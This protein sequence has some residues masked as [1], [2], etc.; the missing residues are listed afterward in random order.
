MSGAIWVRQVVSLRSGE[1]WLVDVPSRTGM[2]FAFENIASCATLL[3]MAQTEMREAGWPKWV[4]LKATP[5]RAWA[6]YT[7]DMAGLLARA[8]APSG[9]VGAL[10]PLGGPGGPIVVYMHP[11]RAGALDLGGM[12]LDAA[13]MQAPASLMRGGRLSAR[14]LEQVLPAEPAP[15]GGF[16]RRLFQRAP[17]PVV[18]QFALF[19]GDTETVELKSR[20][21]RAGADVKAG[22]GWLHTARGVALGADL[23]E[24]RDAE[25]DVSSVRLDVTLS[26]PD[27]RYVVESFAGLGRTLAD[28]RANA[29]DNMEAS[30][31]QVFVDALCGQDAEVADVWDAELPGV[32]GERLRARLVCGHPAMRGADLEVP[33]G[34]RGAFAD[35]VSAEPVRGGHVFRVFIAFS[36]EACTA[37]EA[38]VD[39]QK[40][41]AGE[42]MLRALPWQPTTAYTSLRAVAICTTDLAGA[43]DAAGS[44]APSSW[45]ADA[46]V[47]MAVDAMRGGAAPNAVY[48]L[49]RAGGATAVQAESVAA[50]LPMACTRVLFPQATWPDAFLVARGEQTTTFPLSES[51]IFRAAQRAVEALDDDARAHLSA[52]SAEHDALRR[53]TNGTFAPARLAD[54][55]FS[56]SVIMVG[57]EPTIRRTGGTWTRTED[58]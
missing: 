13:L 34:F 4:A 28:K 3:H 42:A 55:V 14:E 35:A 8:V 56:P 38:L 58:G 17:E 33:E 21:E 10:S 18:P 15:R 27:G 37:V 54:A 22:E 30:A 51:A 1:L 46:G 43:R 41:P 19:N 45:T 26:F 29:F 9:D 52:F 50:L 25:G 49:M 2:R 44:P 23:E 20:L 11:H 39:G 31:L 48:G 12:A 5:E 7:L 40:W 24:L 57:R 32:D 6:H 16:L 53:L 47:A 36:G